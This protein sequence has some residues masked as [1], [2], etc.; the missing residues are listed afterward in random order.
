MSNPTKPAS[1]KE[2]APGKPTTLT[3]RDKL[4]KEQWLVIQAGYESGAVVAELARKYG[5]NITTIRRR[6]VRHKWLKPGELR[7]TSIEEARAEVKAEMKE[8]FAEV[9]KA[10]NER[11]LKS[12]QYA[13]VLA[14]K[15]MREI[16]QA[17]EFGQEQY[18]KAR[19]EAMMTGKPV[20][21]PPVSKSEAQTLVSTYQVLKSAILEGERVVLGI[22]ES[23]LHD[24]TE[25]TLAELFKALDE[26]RRDATAPESD[27]PEDEAPDEDG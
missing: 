22:D 7:R 11:H 25:N 27:S 4:T 16:Q 5:V 6:A 3:G 12:F 15:I 17:L 2:R 18:L 10:A 9:A 24:K 8:T 1:P 13:Q 21:A 23:T 19:A 14:Q 26:A 20:P